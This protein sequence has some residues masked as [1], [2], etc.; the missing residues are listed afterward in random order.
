MKNNNTLDLIKIR[1]SKFSP[2]LYIIP[3]FIFCLTYLFYP[4]IYSFILSF[5]QWSGFTSISSAKFILFENY[6]ELFKDKI[7]FLALKNTFLFVFVAIF[8]QNSLGVALAIS[9][10]YFKMKFG[11]AWRAIIFFP[12]ILSPVIVGLVWRLIF[13][14]E[15]LVNQLLGNLGLNFLQNIWLAN[16]LTPI[17]VITFV[18]I[19]QYTGF[20]MVIY[21]AGL[22]S[23]PEDLIEAAKID[24]AS[25]GHVIFKIIF[26]LLSATASIA[27]VLNIIGGFKV[28]DLVYVMTLGGPAHSSEVLASY[29]Y[30]NSFLMTG[31]SEMGYAASLSIVLTIIVFIISLIRIRM[32]RDIEY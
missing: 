28:F 30:F 29:M 11:K 23:I 17:W 7:F 15:G 20:N 3:A 24:G 6:K 26:P 9:L 25:W 12:A 16:R 22:Q 4:I 2:Y 19:W 5:F 27:I 18:N 21:Y 10:N 31:P 13:A 14:N 32:T 1:N 8:F